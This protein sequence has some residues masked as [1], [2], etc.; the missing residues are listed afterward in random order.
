MAFTGIKTLPL[1]AGTI[2]SASPWAGLFA[3]SGFRVYPFQL[4]AKVRSTSTGT[5][6]TLNGQGAAAVNNYVIFC[7]STNY[8]GANMFIPDLTKI[9]RIT[10]VSSA[11][12]AVTIDS[13]VNITAGDYML[14]IG[15]D[16]SGTP[17][18]SP[19]Y[20]G[21]TISLYSDNTGVTAVSPKYL[22]TT[23]GGAFIG[24]VASGTYAVDLLITNSSGVPQA[25][26]PFVAT[27]PNELVNGIQTYTAA[28]ATPS[29]AG[30]RVIKVG[31]SGG[32]TITNLTGGSTGQI[33]TLIFTD[34]NSTIADSGNF[35]LTGAFSSTADDTLTLV[36][37]GTS[38]YE[39]S[40]AAN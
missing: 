22:S 17:E 10:A 13:A 37:D 7:T 21:S 8:G 36:F 33:V 25:V 5:A 35:K 19:S 11:D 1:L 16:T 15:N 32:V 3:R 31:Q 18:T 9:R 14:L 34:S 24:W 20:D 12:D 40:R 27:I 6:V 28:G 2:A 38:W 4:G 26:Q 23:T 39:I 29:V 30:F